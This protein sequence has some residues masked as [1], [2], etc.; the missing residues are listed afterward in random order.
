MDF[1]SNKFYHIISYGCQANVSDSERYAG[2]LEA[3]GY[4]MT[5]DMDMAD[6]ILLNT[7]CVRETT[8]G[9]TLGKIGE[10]TH[11]KE[12]NK[13]LIIAVAGCMAQ[14][15]QD[16]LFERAPHIDLVIGTH[17][18]H[19]LT[20]LIK[21]RQGHARHYMAADMSVPAF[22][23]LPTKRFQKFFAWVPIMNGCNKFCTYCIVPYVRGREVSRPI[24][25]IVK[26]M[27]GLA[28][29]GYKEI[30]L[31][32]QNV[33]S[34]GMDLKDGTDFSAL[35]QAVDQIDGIERVRYM[36]SHPK[37][38]T[39][40]MIDAIADSKKVVNQM[41]LPI[42]SGSDRLLKKMNRGYTVEHYMELVDYARKRIPDLVLTTD[43]IVGFPGETEE[44]FQ[45]T[46]D[47]LRRV[48]YDMAYTFIYSPRTGTPAAKMEDQI[49]QEEKSRRL[50]HLMDVQ[51]VYSLQR[52]Q[53]MEHHTYEVIVEGPTKN[54][55]N[56]WFGRTRGNK[57]IIWENDGSVAVGDTVSAVVD[58][59]Q[60]WVLKGHLV[61]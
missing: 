38:M 23:D 2:Q 14:E 32:G 31:L 50:Q 22:H 55:E 15:W 11:S 28:Q 26:E 42:Q 52:N 49:P 25:D 24:A 37:D 27:E 39:F 30:T 29:E 51:N 5:E 3:L 7:C 1:Q 45:E 34:Y 16:K 59:G 20:E 54:D 4:H 21:E 8:E 18:I 36:T 33:N 12:L 19:K 13:D 60:T 56:H 41:H 57:M 46:L 47:L 40:A 17:N 6:V 53:A 48:Q 43:L 61:H 44:M 9:K 10:L 35:L 58:K